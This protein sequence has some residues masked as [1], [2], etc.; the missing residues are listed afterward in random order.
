MKQRRIGKGWGREW[1]VR[2]CRTTACTQTNGQEK[3]N[4]GKKPV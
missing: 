3:R 2:P 4:Y 1:G